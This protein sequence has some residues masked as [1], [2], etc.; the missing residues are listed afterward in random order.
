MKV[1][2]AGHWLGTDTLYTVAVTLEGPDDTEK[3]N[4]GIRGWNNAT[5]HSSLNIV[6]PASVTNQ[7]DTKGA[8]RDTQLSREELEDGCPQNYLQGTAKPLEYLDSV[9][10]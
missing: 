6:S 8:T 9:P 7:R 3:G 2:K 10:V 1:S 5:Q 4:G